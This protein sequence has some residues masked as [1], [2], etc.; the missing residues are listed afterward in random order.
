MF[1]KSQEIAAV[2]ETQSDGDGDIGGGSYDVRL[3]WER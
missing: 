2:G 1:N 3:F